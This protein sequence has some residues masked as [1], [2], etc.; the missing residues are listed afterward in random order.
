MYWSWLYSLKSLTNDFSE[1]DYPQFMK[2]T[3]WQ[4]E[5]LNT[6]LGSWAELRHD[7]ILYVEQFGGEAAGFPRKATFRIEKPKETIHYILKLTDKGTP[8]LSR[9]KRVIIDIMPK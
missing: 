8:A 2:T 3:A 7:T 6:N 4:D 1:G 5:K 9:Y